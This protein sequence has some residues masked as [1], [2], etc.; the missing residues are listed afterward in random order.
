MNY[1]KKLEV[2]VRQRTAELVATQQKLIAHEKAAALGVFTAAIGGFKEVVGQGSCLSGEHAEDCDDEGTMGKVHVQGLAWVEGAGVAG[3]GF[4]GAVD[5]TADFMVDPVT[6]KMIPISQ[7][8]D[9]KPD[10]GDFS[11]S[12]V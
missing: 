5:N 6:K 12:F 8:D 3:V 10:G 7:Y 2:D 1:S 9:G 4:A 11:F